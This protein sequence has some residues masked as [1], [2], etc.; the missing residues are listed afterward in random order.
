MAIGSALI[1]IGQ[2]GYSLYSGNV[3][4]KTATSLGEYN[5][6]Q[7][8]TA[9][10]NE[11]DETH[12]EVVRM[13]ADKRAESASVAAQAAASGA[14]MTGSPLSV[15]GEVAKQR[16][17]QIQDTKRRG[18]IQAQQLRDQ[19]A[20]ASY[21]SRVQARSIK[22]GSWGGAI[23]SLAGIDYKGVGKELGLSGNGSSKSKSGNN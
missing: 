17:V 21:Q 7:Y 8:E 2:A 16:E 1:S 18:L 5:R 20:L 23:N 9:A 22:L 4:A 6:R 3:Q 19:G 15:L 10:R 14:V 11:A 13:Y 12:E